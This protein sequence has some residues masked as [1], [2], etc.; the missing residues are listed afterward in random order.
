MNHYRFEDIYVGLEEEFQVTVTADMF[1]Q[2][3]SIT[4]DVNPLHTDE[5]FATGKG[6]ESR[7]GAVQHFH[8]HIQIRMI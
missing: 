2:F 8:N 6:Y 7:V 4:G 5:E 1:A 3:R